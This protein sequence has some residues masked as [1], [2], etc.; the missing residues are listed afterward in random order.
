[1]FALNDAGLEV[2]LVLVALEL[3]APL[4]RL[5]AASIHADKRNLPNVA[6][7]RVVW[8]V[9]D[10]LRR[11][12]AFC[13]YSFCHRDPFVGVLC[14]PEIRQL[15][16]AIVR[17]QHVLRLHVTVNYALLMR[18][19]QPRADLPQDFEDLHLIYASVFKFFYE[20]LLQVTAAQLLLDPD[21]L[22]ILEPTES[23]RDI[24]ML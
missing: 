10:Q 12:V 18:T 14:Q 8:V 7:S 6:S 19:L 4:L 24:L 13:S 11:L 9:S 2:K 5:Y 15:Q 17:H 1:M 20:L 3:E 16:V 23:L 21:L 22:L